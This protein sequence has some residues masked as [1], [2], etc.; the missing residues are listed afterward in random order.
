MLLSLVLGCGCTALASSEMRSAVN[1]IRKVVVMLQK[2]QTEVTAEGEKEEDLYKKFMCYC[3]TG[4][5]TLEDSIEAN[6]NKIASL[7]SQLKGALAEKEQTS[8]ALSEHKQSRTDAKKAIAEATAMR[9][10]EA[11]A[12]AKEE[13][14]SNMNLAALSKAIPAIENGV[15]G[16]FL[17]TNAANVIRQFAMEKAEIADQARQELL[18]FLSGSQGDGY[19]PQSGEIVGIL[20]TLKDEMEASLKSATEDENAAIQTYDALMAAKKKEVAT[21]TTQIEKEMQRLGELEVLLATGENQIE[22][23]K[24]AVAADT[25]FLE[26][27]KAG[28]ETKTAEWEAIKKT[29]AEELV[30][31]AE[32]IKVLN[33]DDALELFKKTLPSA[34]ASF[35][36]MQVSTR[37]MKSRALAAVR[38]AVQKSRGGP[39]SHHP[40]L[41]LIEMALNGKQMGFEKVISMIDELAANLKKEQTDDDS[42]K[43]Y[44]EAE[45]DKSDDKKKSEENSIADSEAAIADMEGLIATLTEEIA[46]LEAGIK[47]LDKSVAE[48]TELRKTEH[49]DYETLMTDDTNAKEVML[50]AKN[51]LNKFYNPKLYKAPPARELSAEEGVTVSM[52]GTL[53]PTPA[54]GGI[55]NTGIGALVQMRGSVAPPPPPETFGPY[56]KKTESSTGV[57]AMIDLLIADLDKETQEATVMEKDGQKEYEEMMAD[58]ADKRAQDSKSVTDKTAAKAATEEQLQAETDKKG[59]TTKD[60]ALTIEYIGTLHGECDWLLKYFDVRKAARTDEI[61][62]LGRAKAVLSGADYSLVQTRHLR[63]TRSLIVHK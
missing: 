39:L 23:A 62:A 47:A 56:T 51:R 42:K 13:S 20:K 28:C 30:A 37:E 11:A 44:C 58:S 4:V 38:A 52:G 40:Q 17:Q 3:K 10:K 53:A 15:K 26:E 59:E 33:D 61:E 60:L 34:S 6:K 19:V 36:Q 21:L 63:S 43:E 18:A 35:M 27:L 12:F 29:R 14:D 57:I 9:E 7:E 2:M 46:A 16:A 49:A 1:P 8:A 54:P 55:G 50:W 48:A 25:K 24:E 31:L 32:T 45:F 22:D 41:D 5:G